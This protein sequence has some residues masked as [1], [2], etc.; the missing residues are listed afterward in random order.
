MSSVALQAELLYQPVE[1]EASKKGSKKGAKKGNMN[2]PIVTVTVAE[3]GN[4]E[5]TLWPF[6]AV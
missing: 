3:K 4:S 1:G 6:L 2:D 5:Y